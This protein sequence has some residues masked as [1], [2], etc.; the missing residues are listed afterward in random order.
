MKLPKKLKPEIYTWYEWKKEIKLDAQPN[1]T[2]IIYG[3]TLS[4]TFDFP[5]F[6]LACWNGRYFVSFCGHA[7]KFKAKYFMRIEVPRKE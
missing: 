7:E 3:R 2:F 1:E 4:S 6:E 5:S